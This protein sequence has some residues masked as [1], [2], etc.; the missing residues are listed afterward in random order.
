MPRIDLSALPSPV[1]TTYPEP[2]AEL[3]MAANGIAGCGGRA[4]TTSASTSCVKPGSASSARHWHSRRR[5]VYMIDRRT[6]AVEDEGETI[7][8]PVDAAASG[9]VPRPSSFG[10]APPVRRVSRR[11]TPRARERCHYPDIELAF[12][13]DDESRYRNNAINPAR[14]YGEWQTTAGST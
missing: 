9:R 6:C 14:P 11:R 3:S 2:F 5:L 7:G 8:Q 13:Q 1:G 10:T 12:E 4:L